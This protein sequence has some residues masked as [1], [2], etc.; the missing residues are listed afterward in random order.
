MSWVYP[1]SPQIMGWGCN[2][3]SSAPPLQGEEGP[4]EDLLSL[5]PISAAVSLVCR[6]SFAQV[7]MQALLLSANRCL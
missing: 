1:T 7:F 5:L 4:K 3:Y 6:S 2:D